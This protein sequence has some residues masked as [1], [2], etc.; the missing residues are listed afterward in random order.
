MRISF[1]CPACQSK[2]GIDWD[3]TSSVSCP[4]CQAT[5]QLRLAQQ[6]TIPL[7]HPVPDPPIA[8]LVTTLPCPPSTPSP[9]RW[10]LSVLALILLGIFWGSWSL[11]LFQTRPDIAFTWGT[12]GALVVTVAW[13]WWR[14]PRS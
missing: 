2:T 8:Q 1:I 10:W 9:W 12:N 4:T 13:V 7:A 3:G 14:K 6:A 11:L 5:I